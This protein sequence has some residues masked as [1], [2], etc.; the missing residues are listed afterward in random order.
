MSSPV[1]DLTPE[2]IRWC[3]W[4]L[5]EM[6]TTHPVFRRYVDACERVRRLEAERRLPRLRGEIR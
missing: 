5:L 2:T 1:S 4:F 3:Y 6:Y